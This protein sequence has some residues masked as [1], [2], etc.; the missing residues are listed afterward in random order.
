MDNAA[1]TPSKITFAGFGVYNQTIDVTTQVASL[2]NSGTRVFLASNQWGDP[3]PG[4]RKYLYIGWNSGGNDGSGVVG[5]NDGK[6]I[7]VP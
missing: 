4:A 2:Y 3:A 7:I 5:E 1:I 6:G